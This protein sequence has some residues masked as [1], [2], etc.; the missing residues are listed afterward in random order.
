VRSKSNQDA[1]ANMN[2]MKTKVA[3]ITG[4][5]SG[6][7]AATA[8]LFK[9][10]GAI[11]IIGDLPS[12]QGA[13]I[14]EQLQ[15]SFSPLNVTKEDEWAT[16]V[17]NIVQKFGRLDVLVNGAGIE[18]DL[19]DGSPGEMSLSEW[20]KVM[21][22][23]LDGTFLGCRA[24]LST[25]GP[26]KKG[27]IINISSIA[28]YYPT[29]QSAAYGA[30]KAGVMQLSKS[31]AFYGALKGGQIRCNSVHPGLIETPM[32]GRIFDGLRQRGE[33]EPRARADEFK[34]RIPLGGAGTPDDVAELILFLASD[35]SKYITGSEFLMDGGWRLLR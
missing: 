33:A 19:Q 29:H 3:L 21:A 23:N 18:G 5:A 4:G 32:L 24:A 17:K 35:E 12:S 34:S 28:S 13:K 22:V 9:E 8:S 6:I 31:V 20:R 15:A 25:M 1:T 2:R 30:S 10:E 11:V 16:C 27:S 26:A 14:A 7:G